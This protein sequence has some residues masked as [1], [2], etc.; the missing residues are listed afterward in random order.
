VLNHL[1]QLQIQLFVD[2]INPLSQSLIQYLQ[3]TGAAAV[4][5]I[6]DINTQGGRADW[7]SKSGGG[8]LPF[9]YANA[10]QKSFSGPPPSIATLLE[11][12][13]GPAMM[14]ASSSSPAPMNPMMTESYVHNVK[15]KSF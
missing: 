5:Q 6:I 11:A 1:Q 14:P 12:L 15:K 7:M 4:I 13:A 10:T 8:A 9:F 3:S 2:M